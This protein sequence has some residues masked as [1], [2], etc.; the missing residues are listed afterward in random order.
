MADLS[1]STAEPYDIYID[2]SGKLWRIKE[3]VPAPTIIAEEIEGTL[4]DPNIPYKIDTNVSAAVWPPITKASIDKRIIKDF[5][6]SKYWED[7]KRIHRR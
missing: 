4:N 3:V 7:W 6:S 2:S 1:I 5:T